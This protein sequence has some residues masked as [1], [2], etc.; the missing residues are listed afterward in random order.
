MPWPQYVLTTDSLQK[1]R[2]GGNRVV[3]KMS[4]RL[5]CA[6][7]CA[8][9]RVCLRARTHAHACGYAAPH[10]F[11]LKQCAHHDILHSTGQGAASLCTPR[12][13]RKH[14][15]RQAGRLAA[16]TP[17]PKGTPHARERTR[18]CVSPKL[19]GMFRDDVAH[20]AVTYS[21]LARCDGLHQRVVRHLDQLLALLVH[22]AHAHRLVQVPMV[23]ARGRKGRLAWRARGG[24]PC[25]L[26]GSST[27]QLVKY[28]S[29]VLRRWCCPLVGG[30]AH[31][32]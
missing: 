10:G 22:L 27:V 9:A 24:R 21:R 28:A 17:A 4:K 6:C 7:V 20:V 15:S 19:A 14:Q 23:P 5:W 16:T 30:T 18:P 11:L 13:T 29:E 3:F 26:H 12:G 31:C 8:R 1:G 2:G 32:S 25:C